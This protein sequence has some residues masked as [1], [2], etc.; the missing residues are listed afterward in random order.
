MTAYSGMEAATSHLR[1]WSC[2]LGTLNPCPS[3]F[4]D[5]PSHLHQQDAIH[6]HGPPCIGPQ[7]LYRRL[8]ESLVQEI[9]LVLPTL[10]ETW[11][12]TI[13]AEEVE[14]RA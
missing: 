12:V 8:S 1:L 13:S 3:R 11:V 7:A 14:K 2:S 9:D 10:N 6:R 5:L 4:S